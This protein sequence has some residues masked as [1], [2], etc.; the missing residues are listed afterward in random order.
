MPAYLPTLVADKTAAG[1]VVQ[2]VLA[3]LFYRERSGAGQQIEVPMFES[4]A[5]WL[6]VEHLWGQT[7]DPPLAGAGYP[8]LL[9]GDRRPYRCQDGRYLSVLP[10][11]D[12]HW[13]AFCRLAGRPE[14]ITDPRFRDLSA[15]TENID[16]TYRVTREIVALKSCA[17]WLDLLKDSGVPVAEL[18]RL[19]DLVDDP[20]LV[21]AEFWKRCEHPTEGTLRMPAY[22]AS[23]GATPVSIR[24]HP[25][26][27]G[28]H[29][30]DVLREIGLEHTSIERMLKAGETLEPER[31]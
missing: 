19:D 9:S 20:H 29:S 11:R 18:K 2:A 28:E 5:S 30:V 6:M 26:R 23:F 21:A 7:F 3:A 24:R 27:L 4:I 12:A 13:N 16:Q 31:E 1:F 8:R 17:E 15:R 14:L 22:P 10:Y 25:P